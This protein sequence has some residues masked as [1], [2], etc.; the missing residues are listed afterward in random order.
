M[1]FG[2]EAFVSCVF[3]T[4]LQQIVRTTGPLT[5]GAAFYFTGRGKAFGWKVN[6]GGRLPRDSMG[7]DKGE[8]K[9]GRGEGSRGAHRLKGLS[10]LDP[11]LL[12]HQIGK[13][14]KLIPFLDSVPNINKGNGSFPHLVFTSMFSYLEEKKTNNQ[15]W[16]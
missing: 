3:V 6:F 7:S 16:L 12:K 11:T 1:W 4:R 5:L 15:P 9:R 10:L 8:W 14:I 2:S 13:A